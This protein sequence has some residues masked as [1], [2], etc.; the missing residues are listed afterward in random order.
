MYVSITYDITWTKA[1]T[2]IVRLLES[3]GF[4]VQKSVFEVELNESQ[5][6]K[7]KKQLGKILEKAD[8]YYREKEISNEDSIKFYILSKIGEGNLEGRIDGLGAGYEKIYFP[9][10]MIL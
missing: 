7:I 6:T 1:R 8:V 2:Q 3:Y 10:V 9:E 5:Y 4:R